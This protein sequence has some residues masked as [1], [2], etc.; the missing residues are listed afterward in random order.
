MKKIILLL[1]IVF[2]TLNA[3]K[4]QCKDVICLNYGVCVDGTCD[5]PDGFSGAL[6]EIDACDDIV[7][8]NNG[9]CVFGTCNCPEGYSGVNCEIAPPPLPCDSVNCENGGVCDNGT[10]N[11]PGDYEGENCENTVAAKFLGTYDIN[12]N[13]A[14]SIDGT[15]RNF[16]NEPGN[17]KIYQGEDPDEIVLYVQLDLVT[18][19]IPMTVESFGEVDELEYETDLK[20]ESINADIGGLFTINLN[21]TIKAEGELSADF[22]ELEST[23]TFNG[24]LSGVI[25]CTGVKQ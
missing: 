13:G 14:L 4:D 16:V 15:I 1:S 6:C 17:A 18:D 10:C 8:E 19:A 22:Q 25:T 7:C 21:F 11:C 23:V 20:A 5:C 12:C 9:V 24:D 3:C 2:L